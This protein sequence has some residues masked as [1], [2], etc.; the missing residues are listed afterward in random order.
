MKI[1][2]TRLALTRACYASDKEILIFDGPFTA[3]DPHVAKKIY[4]AAICNFL[5]NKTRIICTHHAEYLI[6]ADIVLVIEN[7][8]IIKSGPGSEIIPRFARL[9]RAYK[10]R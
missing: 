5:S 6:N 1:K 3:I 9:K 8:N 4:Q 10:C 7:G 2:R